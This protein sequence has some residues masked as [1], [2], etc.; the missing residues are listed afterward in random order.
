[1][2]GGFIISEAEVECHMAS[3][4]SGDLWHVQS[5]P[6]NKDSFV[7][8]KVKNLNNKDGKYVK[9]LLRSTQKFR[10]ISKLV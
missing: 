2:R 7:K 9:L 3:Y 1:L 8:R 4:E 6:G 5:I 10:T